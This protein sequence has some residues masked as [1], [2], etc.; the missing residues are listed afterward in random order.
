MI[1][2][3]QRVD[4]ADV[5]PTTTLL[6][7]LRERRGLTG[8]KEGCS[9]GDCGACTVGLRELGPDG[10]LV[11][12]PA[13]ACILPLPMLHGREIVTVE[14]L[15]APDGRL[16]PVQ[17]AMAEGHGSQCGFCTPG[18]VMSMWCAYRS[19]PR[20]S[21]ERADALLAGNLCRCTGYGP[22]VAAA[23][24]AHDLPRPEWDDDDAAAA[25][26][27]LATLP[28]TA[29]DY[30]A[31]GR[32]FIAPVTLD[33][34]A[35]AAARNPD[36]TI[37]SGATDV[38]LWITKRHFAPATIIWT[39]R[40][41]GLRELKE[42]DG[43]LT[44]GAAV[45]YREAAARLAAH[46]PDFGKLVARIAGA[47]IRALGTVGGNIAN[48][49]PIGDMPPALIALG[50][51]LQ[52]RHGDKRRE[53]TLDDFFLDYGRQDRAPGEIVTAVTAPLPGKGLHLGCHKVSKRFDQDIT[54]VLGCFAL[55]LEDGHVRQA[56][57][58]YGGMAGVPKRARAAEQAL[59]GQPYTREQVDAAAAALSDDFAPLTDM[60][61][62][63]RYRM[64][65][66]Q[67]LLLRDYLER[68]TPGVETRLA[69]ATEGV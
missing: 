69:P 29:L 45:T 1:L 53:I 21:P 68:T 49:S 43:T 50:A 39:G 64:Q 23:S 14:R 18:F 62:S 41:A 56:R 67:N 9:E 54:S 30:E 27:R 20:P 38:G 42:D 3:G 33:E 65:V 61:A 25:P 13:C 15:A 63:A 52:L 35:D 51:R 59:I 16:H 36:A 4:V 32:R 31:D 8:T 57:L 55:T 17:Q 5:P 40:V 37:L 47:Q 2:N 48:G 66:A 24:A 44:I 19:E 34:L 58:A 22:I 7:W 28:T 60:R 10:K 12:M 26:T 46:W 6:A 11:T